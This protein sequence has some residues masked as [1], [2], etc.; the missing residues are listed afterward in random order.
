MKRMPESGDLLIAEDNRLWMILEID[1]TWDL[2]EYAVG[3]RQHYLQ[4]L[5]DFMD[6][7]NGYKFEDGIWKSKN[8]DK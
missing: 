7:L 3:R 5:P 1:G 4:V 8:Y 2:F 6:W